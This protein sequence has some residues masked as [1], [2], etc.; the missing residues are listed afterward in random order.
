M[1]FIKRMFTT[2]N[3]KG[4]RNYINSQKKFEILRTLLY[5]ALPLGLFLIGYITTKTKVNLMTIV[6]VV[7][8]LPA[9]KSLV[10]AIMFL[11]YKSLLYLYKVS[12]QGGVCFER[13]V[14]I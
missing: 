12:K 6:A 13:K 7:G 11:R 14:V 9:S 3:V 4:T 5:F 8:C 1:M 10:G 2:E